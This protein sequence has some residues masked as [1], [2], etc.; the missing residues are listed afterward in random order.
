MEVRKESHF[1]SGRKVREM[2]TGFSLQ[3]VKLVWGV[4][5]LTGREIEAGEQ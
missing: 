1:E 3:K 5:V 2:K 4:V